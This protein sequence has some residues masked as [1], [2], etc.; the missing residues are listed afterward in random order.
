MLR[1]I[2]VADTG[3]ATTPGR[4]VPVPYKP[5]PPVAVAAPRPQFVRLDEGFSGVNGVQ[6]RQR[7]QRRQRQWR[8]QQRRCGRRCAEGERRT[9]GTDGMGWS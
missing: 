4:P 9:G 2:S 1:S 5:R 7:H 3:G 6:R 8:Q